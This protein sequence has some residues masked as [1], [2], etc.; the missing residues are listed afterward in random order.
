MFLALVVGL[1]SGIAMSARDWAG[2]GTLLQVAESIGQLW[3]DALTMTVVPLVFGLLITGLATAGHRAS[4]SRV[5]WR[6]LGWFAILLT[7]ACALAALLSTMLLD[8]WPV[9]AVPLTV[10]PA[11][12]TPEIAPAA[13]WFRNIIP[14]NPIKAAAETAIVPVV[15]FALFFGFAASRIERDLNEAITTFF[16]AV[17]QTMLV[18]V[19]W[20]LWAAPAGIAA[21][22]FAAGA[23]MGAEAA[24]TL[25]H[26]MVIVV[27]VCLATTL[28]TYG[29]AALTGRM[30][31]LRFARAAVPAQA[32]ALGTR[33]SLASLPVMINA[34]PALG[35]TSASAGVILPLAVSLFRAAS[36]AANVAVAVYLAH[37]HGVPLSLSIITTGVL[38]AIP[39]SLAAVGLPAQ[40]SFFTTIGPICMAMGVPIEALPLLLAVEMVP[41]F[42]RTLGNVTADLAATRIAGER[43]DAAAVT[44]AG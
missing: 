28:M 24:G 9:S 12:P 5:V 10:E 13:E 14:A 37:L 41:D 40:I 44:R 42:F 35:V 38:V 31:I 4:T 26:Y 6:S 22:A 11:V 18:V 19:G 34:A 20:V 7:V 29:A 43:A 21:L 30:S 3:L 2:K 1:G 27:I 36:A 8:L 32:V 17:V 33:S 23:R 16:R 39:V 25:V 15:I